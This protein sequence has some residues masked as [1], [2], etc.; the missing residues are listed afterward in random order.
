MK[1]SETKKRKTWEDYLKD[2]DHSK[3]TSNVMIQKAMKME[4]SALK[5][6][7]RSQ[8]R[9]IEY[10]KAATKMWREAAGRYQRLAAKGQP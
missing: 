5:T 2:M 3:G 4:I 7:I 8:N 9:R 6:Y 1:C 10:N